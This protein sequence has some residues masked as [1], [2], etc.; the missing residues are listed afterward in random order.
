MAIAIL[1]VSSFAALAAGPKT[2]GPWF[3][4]EVIKCEMTFVQSKGKW[5]EVWDKC[6]GAAANGIRS[7]LK[8]LG[9]NRFKPADSKGSWHYFVARSGD[10]EVRDSQGVVRVMRSTA[11]KTEMQ[12]TA[13]ARSEGVRIG[14]SPEQVIASSWGKPKKINRTTTAQGERQQWVY[15]G[16]YLYFT[17]GVLTGVQN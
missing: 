2:L 7:D 13:A 8:V 9:K 14:M 3:D 1:G 12:Q 10:L 11:P 4:D 17:N 6:D 15:S 5:E 16:G